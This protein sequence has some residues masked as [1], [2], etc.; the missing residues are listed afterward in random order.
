MPQ[1]AVNFNITS[2]SVHI[3]GLEKVMSMRKARHQ[4]GLSEYLQRLISW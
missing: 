3:D 1:T 4:R 2:E